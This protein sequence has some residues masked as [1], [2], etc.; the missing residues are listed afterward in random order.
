MRSRHKVFV[1]TAPATPRTLVAALEALPKPRQDVE[2]IHFLVQGAV[3]IDAE[4]RVLTR[5]RHR[6]FFAGMEM[7][8]ALEQ[9]VAEYH[10]VSL[11]RVPELFRIGRI[12]LD[13]AFV[14]V[15]PPDSY[16]YVSLG[17]AVD[18]VAAAVRHA[19][20]VIAEV[21]PAMPWTM[22]DSTVHL[23]D[24]HH[25]VHVEPVLGEYVHP[26]V[27][28]EVVERVARY[29][30]GT[31]DDGSTL[32]IGLGRI[33]NHALKY[34]LDRKDLGIHSDV[35]TDAILPLLERGV[36]TGRQ[37]SREVGKIVTSFATGTRRLYDAID[38]N[39]LFNFQ[40]IDAICD[41][42]V[43]ASQHK[44]VSVMQAFALDLTGDVVA[45]QFNGRLYGGLVAQAEFLR[46]AACSPG[47]KPIICLAS[48]TDEGATSCIR[49]TLLPGEGVSIPRAEVHYV[50]TEYG[51][52]YLYGR[53]LRERALQLVEIAH[54]RHR[55]WLLAEAKRLG[56]VPADQKVKSNASYAVENER[57]VTLKNGREVRLRP[58]R[59]SD[60]GAIR[61]LFFTLSEEDVYTRFF[62]KV[63]SL[64]NTQ[65]ERLCNFDHEDEVGFV[66]VTGSREQE[67]L[68]G[69]SCYFVT[70]AT[71]MAETAFVI[72]P[73]W[74]GTGLGSALQQRM[75]EHARQRG[76]RGFVAEI[77]ADN[78][79][80]IALA[81]RC[82][83]NVRVERE[84]DVVHVI[85][86][87]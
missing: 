56:Y 63:Q 43:L 87:L 72:D 64:T 86:M 42:A 10:P 11:A 2:L 74:Q 15:T 60:A 12:P 83:D 36:I 80:M 39:S 9:G 68:V 82:S 85:A 22:G 27:A 26:P 31:I 30:A 61:R 8:P 69:Q 34:L 78:R 44:F 40:P 52:A 29:I 35:I 21:N 41:P 23:R 65:V 59:A 51:I 14:Q 3:P 62:S 13:V 48:T 1:G 50:I 55:E 53:S 47:G 24:I 75:A 33:P 19:K 46:G 71:N 6:C 67:T 38:R 25:L 79:K 20:L 84:Y 57:Q 45:D 76:V 7:R 77:L 58:A 5:Y 54:P 73:R 70:P 16:G 37:K 49:P 4:G 66:A 28:E 18:I 32:Q 81:R 17:L